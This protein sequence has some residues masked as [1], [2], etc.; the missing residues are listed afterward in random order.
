M[1]KSESSPGFC[2]ACSDDGH[3]RAIVAVTG[4][5]LDAPIP[6][7]QNL[8]YSEVMHLICR[9]GLD[10]MRA[11]SQSTEL[12][13]VSQAITHLQRLDNISQKNAYHTSNTEKPALPSSRISNI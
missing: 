2:S 5:F 4:W 1:P 10:I 8:S 11:E 7:Q 3:P 9:L 12:N 13:K 6:E